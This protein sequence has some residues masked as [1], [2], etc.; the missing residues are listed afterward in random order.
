MGG[1]PVARRLAELVRREIVLRRDEAR[2]A[3]EVEYGFRHALVR[4]AAYGMLTERDRRVGHALAG[5]WL[6]RAGGADP[7]A[8]A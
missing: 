1:A 7:T 5:E 6:E 4:E 8:L 2:I 3:G